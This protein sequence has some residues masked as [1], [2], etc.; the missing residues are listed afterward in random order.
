[1]KPSDT[2]KLTR[3]TSQS[4]R[5]GVALMAVLSFKQPRYSLKAWLPVGVYQ[6]V[7]VGKKM[8]GVVTAVI[9]LIIVI[10]VIRVIRVI[11]V[12]IMMVL[13][14]LMVEVISSYANQE[15]QKITHF[16][17]F[18]HSSVLPFPPFTALP[19]PICR[20]TLLVLDG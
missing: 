20:G 8:P 10:I 13:I 19:A 17:H 14:V 7:V 9:V 2:Y 18:H 4:Q 1:M 5:T 15:D 6:E 12:K 3:N 16:H 11:I